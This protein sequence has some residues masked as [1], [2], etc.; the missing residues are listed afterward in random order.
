MAKEIILGMPI[1]HNRLH[2]AT[3]EENKRFCED[4]LFPNSQILHK[5]PINLINGILTYSVACHISQ[6]DLPETFVIISEAF[7]N[8]HPRYPGNQMSVVTEFTSVEF[9]SGNSW[10]IITRKVLGV[11]E[12]N[13][14]MLRALQRIKVNSDDIQ[15]Y[16]PPAFL[17]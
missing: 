9:V 1:H 14:D 7:S 10:A 15:I 4:Q 2:L 12:D 6:S 3:A 16:A 11:D 17:K 8:P 5:A 13:F